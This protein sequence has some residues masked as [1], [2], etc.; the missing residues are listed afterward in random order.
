M[1]IDQ[2]TV[3]ILDSAQ[4]TSSIIIEVVREAVSNAIRHGDATKINI[5]ISYVESQA[6]VHITVANNGRLLPTESTT[7][8]GAKLLTDMTLEWSRENQVE[9]V[10][11]RAIAP[12][13]KGKW[14]D[15]R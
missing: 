12:I 1:K 14:E 8:I 6:D 2:K 7:G 10:V 3:E 5:E 11:L 9:G 13:Q 4:T 15:A